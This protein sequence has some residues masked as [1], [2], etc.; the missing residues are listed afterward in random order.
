MPVYNRENSVHHAIQSIL[1][2]TFS[3]WELIIVDD[4]STDNTEKIIKL[5]KDPRIKYFKNKINKGISY[6]RNFG[7]AKARG[8]IIVVQDSD[9]MS[10]PDRLEE[11]DKRF[12]SFSDTQVLY[13]W[14][15]IRAMDIRYGARAA[16]REIH[17][18]GPYDKR[19]ALTQPYI[20]GQL[21][22]R[23]EVAKKCPYRLEM[24]FW[25]DWMFIIDCTMKNIIFSELQ[26]PLYEY[27]ISHDSVTTMSDST[28]LREQEKRRMEN[29]LRK[30]YKLDVR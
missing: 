8:E 21:A 20:P 2:Q 29:I 24:R 6:S 22:Y 7:N 17:R 13:H 27:V 23:R 3:D 14:F 30:E 26:R 15:Y 28:D 19:R 12:K 10:L 1:D 9:D 11:I 16:H 4:G 18:C 5:F 25:D